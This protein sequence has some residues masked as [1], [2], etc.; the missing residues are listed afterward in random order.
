MDSSLER[1]PKR[2]AAVLFSDNVRTACGIPHP[3]RYARHLLLKEKAKETV[4]LVFYKN[5]LSP[6][7]SSLKRESERWATV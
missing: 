7:D 6:T 2:L 4:S 3:S 5:S 1:E